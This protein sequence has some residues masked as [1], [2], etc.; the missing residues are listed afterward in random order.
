MPKLNTNN[1]EVRN[2]FLDVCTKWV[3]EYK[4]DGLRFDVANEI[5]HTFCKELRSRMKAINPE[6]Y[7][8]GEIWHDAMGWLRE[9]N[10]TRS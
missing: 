4:V 5:S 6:I 3:K 10:L 1:A 8:L 9:T 7:I 2:Y